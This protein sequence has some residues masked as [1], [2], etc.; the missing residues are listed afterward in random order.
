MSSAFW[1]RSAGHSENPMWRA[2]PASTTSVS[3][4]I[5]SSQRDAVVVAVALVEVDVVGLQAFQRS[6]DLLEDLLARQAAVARAHREVDLRRE[7][8]AVARIV[9]R[10]SPHAV[11]AAPVPYTLAVSNSVIPASNAARVHASVCSRPIPPEYVSH[12]PSA[13]ARHG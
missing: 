8:V 6:V 4:P 7:H 2:L 1:M 9:L 11:S 5:V 10:I 3:A 12:D 13:T